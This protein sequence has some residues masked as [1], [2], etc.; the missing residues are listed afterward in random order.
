M[1]NRQV[2]A[3]NIVGLIMEAPSAQ[4][5]VTDYYSAQISVNR[6]HLR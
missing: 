2:M 6:I 5:N 1:K 3:R 4:S